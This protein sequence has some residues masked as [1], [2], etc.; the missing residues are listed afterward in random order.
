MNNNQTHFSNDHSNNDNSQNELQN[1]IENLNYA[2]SNDSVPNY[3][4][5]NM[6][7]VPLDNLSSIRNFETTT[8][9]FEPYNVLADEIVDVDQIRSM[10]ETWEMQTADTKMP[11]VVGMVGTYLAKELAKMASKKVLT[12]LYDFLFPNNNELTMKAILEATE[13]MMDRKIVETVRQIVEQE[14]VGLQEIIKAC[15]EDI[16]AFEASISLPEEQKKL[17]RLKEYQRTGN[18]NIEPK[19]IIEILNRTHAF[20]VNRMPQFSSNNPEWSIELLPLYAQAANLHLLFLRDIIKSATDWQL[21]DAELKK[22]KERFKENINKYSN[23]ALNTYTEGFNATYNSTFK[24]R[25]N[26]RNF[27]VFNVLDYVST[28]SMLRYEAVSINSSANIYITKDVTKATNFTSWEIVNQF[29]QGKPYKI[30]SGVEAK[31]VYWGTHPSGPPANIP[32][33]TFDDL[34]NVKTVYRGG[35]SIGPFGAPHG[36][37]PPNYYDYKHLYTKSFTLANPID[38][39]ITKVIQKGTIEGG[40]TAGVVYKYEVPGISNYSLSYMTNSSSWISYPDYTVKHVMGINSRDNGKIN[41]HTTSKIPLLKY[42]NPMVQTNYRLDTLIATFHRKPQIAPYTNTENYT[43]RHTVPSDGL[44][45]TISPLQFYKLTG[46]HADKAYIRELL[47]NHGDGVVFPESVDTTTAYKYV[48]YNPT[49][50]DRKY[51]IYLKLAT[52]NGAAKFWLVFDDN[53][54]V[55]Y[56]VDTRNVNDGINEK[57]ALFYEEH[58]NTITIKAG[59]NYV[60]GLTH[61]GPAAILGR[62]M[63]TPANVTPIY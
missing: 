61:Q 52:P 15:L 63:L 30:F 5:V 31:G 29:L 51:R 23:Y 60:L 2:Y 24:E 39:P 43:Y 46:Y 58:Y 62:I 33:F 17:R 44:G 36:T 55:R 34:E 11:A 38:K 27:M 6:N 20:F 10:W 48:I 18:P 41:L 45:F 49:S 53:T 47:A 14:L 50:T 9:A 54:S 57:N 13:E 22:Y 28:W 19:S 26:Y 37:T 12:K 3:E 1:N 42:I 56:D 40:Y 7:N 4:D 25:I 21:P 35:T 8:E 32:A 16:E 59:Q